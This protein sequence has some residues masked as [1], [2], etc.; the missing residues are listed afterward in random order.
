MSFYSKVTITATEHSRILTVSIE[1]IFVH[2]NIV[3]AARKDFE[4][5]VLQ[6]TFH[7]S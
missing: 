3:F 1:I 5:F 7:S 6:Q 2:T 4:T